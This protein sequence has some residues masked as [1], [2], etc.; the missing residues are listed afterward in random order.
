VVNG[1]GTLII[2]DKMKRTILILALSVAMLTVNGRAEWKDGEVGP[3][4]FH[5]VAVTVH[6]YL[7]KHDHFL[8]Q[9][10]GSPFDKGAD[11]RSTE[12]GFTFVGTSHRGN[13][14]YKITATLKEDTSDQLYGM[15]VTKVTI[16]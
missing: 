12:D 1:P 16:K 15:V 7:T 4:L 14:V 5:A 13:H 10:N 8:V 3:S 11:V 2:S 9:P 6:N